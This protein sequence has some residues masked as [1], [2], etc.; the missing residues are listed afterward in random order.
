MKNHLRPFRIH[1]SETVR[2][3]YVRTFRRSGS[4]RPY[5]EVVGLPV[6]KPLGDIVGRGILNCESESF[7][8]LR[9]VLCQEYRESCLALGI[10]FPDDFG[11]CL[12]QLADCHFRRRS[13]SHYLFRCAFASAG[14]Q[15]RD[16]CWDDEKPFHSEILF[17][18][19]SKT[20]QTS[21]PGGRSVGWLYKSNC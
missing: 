10:V 12:G 16:N 17:F 4:V 7:G 13:Q 2:P 1:Q 3:D 20:E 5:A 8:L 9:L 15:R 14:D 6:L 11:R 18:I 19:C 21:F